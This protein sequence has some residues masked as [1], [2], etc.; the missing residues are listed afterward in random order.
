MI[1]KAVGL[2]LIV[3]GIAYLVYDIVF[4]VASGFR[5]RWYE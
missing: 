1:E 3:L 2:V 5:K 4:A